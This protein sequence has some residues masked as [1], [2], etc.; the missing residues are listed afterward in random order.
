MCG[1]VHSAHSIPIITAGNAGGA[2]KSGN[3][4]DYADRSRGP[5]GSENFSSTIGAADFTSNWRGVSYNR[6]LVTILQSMGITPAEYEDKTLNNQ[7]NNRSDI[8]A[9]NQGLTDIGG[10]GHAAGHDIDNAPDTYF[11]SATKSMLADYD[12]KQFKNKLPIIS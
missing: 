9:Q 3:Y 5:V 10:W 11:R 12:L 4:V 2:F 8:G 6:L 7:V 1:L